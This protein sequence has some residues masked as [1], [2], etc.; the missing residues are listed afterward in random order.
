MA[1]LVRRHTSNVEIV[2]STPT[3]SICKI[4]VAQNIWIFI[5]FITTFY[6]NYQYQNEDMYGLTKYLYKN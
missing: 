6:G 3:G 4:F 5:G 2:G 1:K